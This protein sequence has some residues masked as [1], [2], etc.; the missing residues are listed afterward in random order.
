MLLSDLIRILESIAPTGLAESWDNVGLLA[1]DPG[2]PVT[3]A[4]LTIDYTPQVAEEARQHR[5]DLVVAYHPPIFDGLKRIAAPSL[6]FDAIRRGVAI[7]SPHTALDVADGGTNDMLADV[8]GLQDRQPLRLIEPKALACK[9]V[10]FVPEAEVE[11]VAAALFDA[12]AGRI[13]HY[14]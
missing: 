11:R 10:T 8:L 1:G 5:C 9:L 12:G 4:L 13:G 6:I 2:Q 7:Y 3:A 14:T